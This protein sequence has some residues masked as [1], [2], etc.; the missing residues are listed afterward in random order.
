MKVE[1]TCFAKELDARLRG[2]LLLATLM[3]LENSG[4]DHGYFIFAGWTANY[5]MHDG[6]LT[7]GIDRP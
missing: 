5:L 4:K 1:Y 3:R 2:R 6:V 7:I